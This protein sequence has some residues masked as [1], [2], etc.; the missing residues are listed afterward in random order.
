MAQMMGSTKGNMI[1]AHQTSSTVIIAMRRLDSMATC[2][3][4]FSASGEP[5]VSIF[6]VIPSL[7]VGTKALKTVIRGQ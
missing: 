5:L 6:I 3:K 4:N 7:R 2:C 1:I